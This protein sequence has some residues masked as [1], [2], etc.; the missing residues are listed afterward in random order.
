M[1]DYNKVKYGIESIDPVVI[2]CQIH[3]I[4]VKYALS[5]AWRVEATANVGMPQ[6]TYNEAATATRPLRGRK[7]KITTTF[8]DKIRVYKIRTF[9]KNTHFYMHGMGRKVWKR[10]YN[11]AVN[12]TCMACGR[13]RRHSSMESNDIR[14]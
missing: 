4:R 13:H 2:N 11:K 9:T 14:R 12:F 8:V 5:H 7:L 6:R 3:K 1:D 10:P